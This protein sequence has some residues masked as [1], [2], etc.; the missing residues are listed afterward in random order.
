MSLRKRSRTRQFASACQLE[1]QALE[2][3]Q[4]LTADIIDKDPDAQM[5]IMPYSA[6]AIDGGTVSVTISRAGDVTLIGDD[7]PNQV[8]V[9]IQGSTL[10][11]DGLQATK[12]RLPGQTPLPVLEVPLPATVRSLTVSLSSGSD[13]LNVSVGADATIT[14]DVAISLGSGEDS[15]TLRV[16]NADLKVNQN[17]T[18]DLGAGNDSA[19]V[20]IAETA[21]II[22][23]RDIT[24]RA[25]AGNDSIITGDDDYVDLD[26][27]YSVEY[28]QG[29]E[30]NSEIAQNQRIRAGRD[31]N[32][33][34]AAGNDRLTLLNVESGR[35]LSI[36]AA[37]GTDI[38]VASNLRANR[39]AVVTDAEAAALQNITAVNN[40]SI[41]G[42]T[43][44]DKIS[45]NAVDVSRL[46]ADLGAGNDQLSLSESVSVK[47][48]SSVN[49][50][51]GTN[52]LHSGKTQPKITVRRTT[53]TLTSQQSLELLIS[54]LDDMLGE[55]GGIMPAQIIMAE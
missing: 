3:R 51:T 41:R 5:V 45:L 38:I 48:A 8:T 22:A 14:R 55:S 6:P 12:F 47:V 29:L 30:N 4:L 23:T 52:A 25:G 16:T 18:V 2:T 17:I 50:G 42:G 28:F 53:Q 32:V 36:A 40:L 35:D 54:V 15:L 13:N 34:L 49:G 20:F 21:S 44:A 7:K 26:T 46:E 10:F 43:G 27:L 33:D 19:D 11:I 24:I 39:N 31:F 9:Q 37:A 1:I